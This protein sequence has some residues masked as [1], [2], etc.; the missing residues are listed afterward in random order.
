MNMVDN[1]SERTATRAD[2]RTKVQHVLVEY[3]HAID[4]ARFADLEPLFTED[5][6]MTARLAGT[7]YHGPSEIRSYLEA[8][9][10]GMRGLHI[11]VNPDIVIEG[12]E[13]RVRADFIVLVPRGAAVVVGAWGWY[14]DRL[15]YA[16]GRWLFRERR[17]ETQ[18]RLTDVEIA[19]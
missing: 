9:P 4:E 10:P 18:F 11:T 15:S 8:Q 2:D 19:R 3:C 6:V 13:A 14:R 5:A 7:V 1:S 17:I 12:D 16:G